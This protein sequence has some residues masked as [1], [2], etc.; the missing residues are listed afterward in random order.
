MEPQG[1]YFRQY[2]GF[3]RRGHRVI[4]L[5]AVAEGTD[6]WHGKVIDVCDGGAVA[7]GAVFDLNTHR[8]DWFQTN[9]P[10]EGRQLRAS[11]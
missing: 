3:E 4:Y 7:F 2:A 11:R 8:F 9:G 6:S 5:N 10:Y 1:H